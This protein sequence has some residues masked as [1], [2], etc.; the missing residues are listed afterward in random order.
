MLKHGGGVQQAALKYNLPAD[1]WLDLS[2]GINPIGWGVPQIPADK[3]LRLPE[4]GD[5]LV[6]SAA[7]Y[8][9]ANNLLPVAGSQAAIQV[10]SRL[11]ENFRVAVLS[12]TYAEHAHSWGYREKSY[13]MPFYYNNPVHKVELLAFRDLD[14]T[15]ELYDVVV[16]VNPNNPTGE[17]TPKEKLLEWRQ[18]LADAGKSAGRERWLIVDEAFMDSTPEDSLIS[19][20]GN[21]GLIVLRSLGKFFGLAGVRVGFVFGWP[22]LLDSMHR[23]L[24]PWHITGPS[25]LVAKEA[26]LDVTWHKKTRKRLLLNSKKLYNMLS[27]HDLTPT[28]GTNLFQW[29][30][31][32][33]NRELF[34]RFAQQGILVRR[35][36]KP[37][38]IRFGL[39]GVQSEWQRLEEALFKIQSLVQQ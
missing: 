21:P 6:T 25:R 26:L 39:P 5:G 14:R 27:S 18:R 37:G 2:T 13:K 38:G 34:D 33:R 10:L 23:L 8:Y 7:A 3:W 29:V 9:G 20:T 22:E 31:V 24:G 19:E 15:I 16:V 11:T 32:S 35:F 17:F 28:G 12:P 4:G 30:K 1:R 36:I